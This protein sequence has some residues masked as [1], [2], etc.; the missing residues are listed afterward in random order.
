[1]IRS[2]INRI[3]MLTAVMVVVSVIPAAA[4]WNQRTTLSFSG[5]VK[6]P[7]TTLPAGSYVFEMVDPT[8]MQ[9]V[10]KI[11]SKDG[12]QVYTV[13]HAVPMRRPE[14][15]EDLV[16]M[17]NPTEPG[18]APALK[19]WYAPG[20]RTGHELLYSEAEA[21]EIAQ[22]TRS[23]VLSRDVPNS[24]QQAGLIVVY[25]A[26]GVRRNWQQDPVTQREWDQW[27]QTH[28]LLTAI[29]RVF[30]QVAAAEAGMRGYIL[31]GQE[32]FLEPYWSQNKRSRWPRRSWR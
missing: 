17:F 27:R 26:D 29:E 23:I 4:Q 12:S 22:R 2:T 13:T 9:H 31:T 3:A 8:S 19:G 16:V 7:G 5:P 28:E 10:V 32:V 11:A 21:R 20:S 25:N 24:S 30:H 15:T 1:M 18:M 14:A 6:V